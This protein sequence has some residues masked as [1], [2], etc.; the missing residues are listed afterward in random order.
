MPIGGL[1]N[2]YIFFHFKSLQYLKIDLIT[3]H[4]REKEHL[5]PLVRRD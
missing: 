5:R 2:I 3:N 4:K 1:Q